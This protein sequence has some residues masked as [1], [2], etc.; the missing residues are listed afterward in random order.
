MGRIRGEFAPELPEVERRYARITEDDFLT[1]LPELTENDLEVIQADL[2][3]LETDLSDT[4]DRL[5]N[6][7]DAI[8]AEL[9]VRYQA[10][11]SA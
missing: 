4:R 6:V 3:E 10:A 7:H 8:V 1:R 11:D 2:V 5:H 9:G